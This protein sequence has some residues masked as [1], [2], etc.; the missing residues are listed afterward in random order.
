[1]DCLAPLLHTT[2]AAK[3]RLARNSTA[4]VH[5]T[6]SIVVPKVALVGYPLVEQTKVQHS[7]AETGNS[8]IAYT[9]LTP[10]NRATMTHSFAH[11]KN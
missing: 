6:G 2:V 8:C 9:Q 7:V 1:M 4:R 10:H 3:T 11:R 5:Y